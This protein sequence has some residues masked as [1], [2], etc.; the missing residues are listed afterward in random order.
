VTVVGSIE[1]YLDYLNVLNQLDVATVNAAA[2]KYL[3]LDKAYT[4]V[5]VPGEGASK[6]GDG[7]EEAE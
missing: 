5:M 3:S 2:R 7:E 1:S 6:S 4:S